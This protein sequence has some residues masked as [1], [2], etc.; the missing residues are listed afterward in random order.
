MT[1][2]A[3]APSTGFTN[4]SANGRATLTGAPHPHGFVEDKRRET[5]TRMRQGMFFQTSKPQA[6]SLR[7]RRQSDA[8]YDRTIRLLALPDSGGLTYNRYRAIAFLD[9]PS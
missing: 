2:P 6:H 3:H 4:S 7:T 1:R 5:P 9:N 8:L